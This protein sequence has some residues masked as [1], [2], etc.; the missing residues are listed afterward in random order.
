MTSDGRSCKV[1]RALRPLKSGSS[2]LLLSTFVKAF[3][4]RQT[5]KAF[6]AKFEFWRDKLRY[7]VTSLSS[8]KLPFKTRQ[9]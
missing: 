8:L 2:P 4:V 1:K 3:E 6:A 5:S 7:R 9:H